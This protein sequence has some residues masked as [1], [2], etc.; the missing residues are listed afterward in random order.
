MARRNRWCPNHLLVTIPHI[1]GLLGSFAAPLWGLE[2]GTWRFDARLPHPI[3]AHYQ[4]TLSCMKGLN[5]HAHTRTSLLKS[6]LMDIRIVPYW[7]LGVAR[8]NTVIMITHKSLNMPEQSPCSKEVAA[9]IT[10]QLPCGKKS[11]LSYS[12]GPAEWGGS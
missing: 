2:P 10:T 1:L 4:P 3:A 12:G 11:H 5:P 9:W 6:V 8:S 7:Q